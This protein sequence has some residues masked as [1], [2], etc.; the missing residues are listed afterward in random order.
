M[1][2]IGKME[3][4]IVYRWGNI[5]FDRQITNETQL[6]D[7]INEMLQR[8]K[9]GMDVEILEVINNLGY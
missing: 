9:D 8:Q 7:F 2:L 6:S 3:L 5:K 1:D 4:V